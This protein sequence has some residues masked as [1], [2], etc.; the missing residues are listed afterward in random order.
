MNAEDAARE[1]GGEAARLGFDAFGAAPAAVPEIERERIDRWIAKRMHGTMAWMERS[2]AVRKDPTLLLPGARSVWIGAVNY[3]HE[4]PRREG[5][6]RVSIY[7]SGRDY[8]RA[9]GG[10]L[11]RLAE[12]ARRVFPGAAV[13][14]FV[15]SAPVLEKYYAERAGIGWRGKHS[16]LIVPGAGSW[17]FLAG[18]LIDRDLAPGERA[19]D[20]CG[21]CTACIDAC[22]TGAIP[23]PYTVDGSRCISYLTIEH[24]GA[25]DSDLAARSGDWIFGCDI[26]QEVCPWNRFAKPAR[27][28]DFHPRAGGASIGLEE[29]LQLGRERFDAR[30]EGSPLRR[31][32]WERFRGS[33]ERAIAN[34]DPERE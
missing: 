27:L 17:F 16:N 28:T 30:F 14:P 6:G 23:A 1:I 19:A 29:A 8:H 2:A 34:R 15:D 31:A 21:S 33:V 26:C 10:L 22:P 3:F 7:A 12:T 32:G 11:R 9:I 18:F 4:A 25:V 13:R 24:R 5:D 20:R